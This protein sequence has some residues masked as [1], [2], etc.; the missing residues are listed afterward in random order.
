[1]Y[2]P[3][4]SVITN[5]YSRGELIYKDTLVG[6]T[7]FYYET[8]DKRYFVGKNPN[9]E[10]EQI[11]LLLVQDNEDVS[12]EIVTT[13]PFTEEL[14]DYRFYTRNNISYSTIK[15]EP[16]SPELL[17]PLP[18]F[19]PSPTPQDYQIGEFQRYFAKKINEEKY[20]EISLTTFNELK[21]QDPKYFFSQFT[22]FSLPW[23]LTGEKEQV[24]RTNKNIIEL[25][26]RQ[27]NV[28]FLGRFLKFN[29]LQFYKN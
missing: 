2:Y 28:F 20:T 9:S 1:M 8:Y 16:E 11:E 18:L 24:A 14:V 25:T 7:G 27:N 22:Q 5:L 29:Y 17:S 15:R 6:Y 19:T 26:E 23:K 10:P 3:K 21:E 4:S 12:E 13:E